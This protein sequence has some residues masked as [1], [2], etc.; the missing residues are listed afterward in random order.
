[1]RRISEPGGHFAPPVYLDVASEDYPDIRVDVA[2]IGENLAVDF[3]DITEDEWATTRIQLTD[4]LPRRCGGIAINMMRARATS[5]TRAFMQLPSRPKISSVK[6][7]GKDADVLI[8]VNLNASPEKFK[9]YFWIQGMLNHSLIL[10]HELKH[11]VDFIFANRTYSTQL[12]RMSDRSRQLRSHVGRVLTGTLSAP[13]GPLL[14][15]LAPSKITAGVALVS[16][17]GG[18]AIGVPS[19]YKNVINGDLSEESFGI[20]QPDLPYGYGEVCA[21][22]YAFA[23]QGKWQGVIQMN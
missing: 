5:P 13:T 14:Y 3:P 19:M 12:E 2:K 17:V 20:K 23:T 21:D 16:I 6:R 15:S 7:W 8:L 1:M 10:A 11:G 9:N 18:A 4:Q 22:A